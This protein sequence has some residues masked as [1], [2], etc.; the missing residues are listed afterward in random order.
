MKKFSLILTFAMLA[1][2][3]T[4]ASCGEKT[5][6]PEQM[7][8]VARQEREKA[9][10]KLKQAGN[11]QITLTDEEVYELV[12]IANKGANENETLFAEISPDE[13]KKEREERRIES[14]R[15]YDSIAK[16]NPNYTQ[17]EISRIV[18][19]LDFEKNRQKNKERI[20]NVMKETLENLNKKLDTNISFEEYKKLTDEERMNLVKKTYN[21]KYNE[22]L[23]ER[24]NH[25]LKMNMSF[26]EY[27]KLTD[28]KRRELLNKTYKVTHD[29][30]K[31]AQNNAK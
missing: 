19:K 18:T 31:A 25:N 3:F 12:K 15:I 2:T 10:E 16:A 22:K 9:L 11:G 7:K 26:N 27:K 24:M 1:I 14:N 29:S 4:L 21:A 23:W 17:I 30:I 13:M 8:I 5:Q 28:E 20:E 6:T